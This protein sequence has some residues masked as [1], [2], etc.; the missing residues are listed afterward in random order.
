MKRK[1]VISYDGAGRATST[2]IWDNTT[3]ILS[4]KKGNSTVAFVV[5]KYPSLVKHQT[6]NYVKGCLLSGLSFVTISRVQVSKVNFL[7]SRLKLC[8]FIEK[9]AVIQP[10]ALLGCLTIYL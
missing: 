1:V 7:F 2:W 4:S 8:S 5:C 9:N 10:A 6:A 3:A